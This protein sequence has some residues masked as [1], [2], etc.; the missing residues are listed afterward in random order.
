MCHHGNNSLQADE[1]GAVFLMACIA[2]TKT[3]TQNTIRRQKAIA[4]YSINVD[5][6]D[7]Y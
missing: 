6:L 7:M 2:V 4:R 3:P 1:S 5:P